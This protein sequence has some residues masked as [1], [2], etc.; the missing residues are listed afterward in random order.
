MDGQ[1]VFNDV[2]RHLITQGKRASDVNGTCFY[3]G[4]EG[5]RCAIG[6]IMPDDIYDPSMEGKAVF[7]PE[8][9]PFHWFIGAQGKDRFSSDLNFL[10]SLQQI[11]D[12]DRSWVMG[13]ARELQDSAD[14]HNLNTDVIRE[15]QQQQQTACAA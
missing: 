4:P 1:R 7:A 13:V 9:K 5:T 2:A 6:G 11:H 10:A 3:R 12:S 8:L 15:L 14:R